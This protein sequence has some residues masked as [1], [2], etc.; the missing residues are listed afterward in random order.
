MEIF[1]ALK[2]PCHGEHLEETQNKDDLMVLNT[3]IHVLKH[4]HV[5]V[6]TQTLSHS[7]VGEQR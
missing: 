4:T 5:S 1:A 6:L 2:Q 7:D 3:H